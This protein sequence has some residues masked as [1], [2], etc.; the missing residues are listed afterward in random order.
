MLANRLDTRHGRL[1]LP[2]VDAYARSA[3]V[4]ISAA[5]DVVLVPLTRAEEIPM[6]RR[7]TSAEITGST[8]VLTVL[9]A[10]LMM[11]VSPVAARASESAWNLLTGPVQRRSSSLVFDSAR[12]RVVVFGGHGVSGYL[13]E[14]WT[15]DLSTRQWAQMQPSGTPPSDRSEHSAIYDPIRD[16][17]I[18]FG[19][20]PTASNDVWSLSF[21]GTPTW[22][23]LSPSGTPPAARMNHAAFYDPVRDRM[24][25]CGGTG[26]SVSTFDVWGLSL[27]GTP[28]W[29]QLT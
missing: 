27:S 17:M 6:A 10:G 14:T 25:V 19:G 9:L 29:T 1:F 7:R 20:G 18:V 24:V 26:P 4:T 12:N 8:T 21:S 2:R 11:V 3:D 28:T 13:G 22:T 23:Q 16:R 15:L 5:D